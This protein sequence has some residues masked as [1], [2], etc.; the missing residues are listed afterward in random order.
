M[1]VTANG[2]HIIAIGGLIS[3]ANSA[4]IFRYALEHARVQTPSVGFLATAS[5]DSG[6]M[7]SRF[8]E[9]FAG[10]PCRP[11][12]LPLFERTPNVQ[13]YVKSVDVLL[14]G[15]G[16][17]RSMLA[18]WRAWN[19]PR[20]LTDAWLSGTILIGWSAGA[21]CWFEQG[22]TDSSAGTFEGLVGLGL[23]K[24]ACSPHYSDEPGR[25]PAFARLLEQKKIGI[26]IGIDGGAALHFVG[27]R[28]TRL[29]CPDGSDGAY[30]VSPAAETPI[31]VERLPVPRS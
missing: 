17:T 26:G 27:F 29:L 1:A 8:Y 18:V 13:D 24:G 6:A 16:N 7:L 21:I 14:V 30:A 5:G 12:H 3:D 4:A 9:S 11:S 25:K 23:L 15:G 2:R 22:L 31:V 28:P 10:L 19:L 20:L